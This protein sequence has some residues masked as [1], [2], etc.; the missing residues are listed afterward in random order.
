MSQRIP[1]AQAATLSAADLQ[2]LG[3]DELQDLGQQLVEW[4]WQ[5]RQEQQLLFYEPVSAEARKIHL[6]T[7]P[8]VCITG[9]NRSSK[10][11]TQLVE[12]AIQLTGLIPH[13]LEADYPREKI[14]PPIRARVVCASLTSTLEPIIKPKLRWDQWNGRD[15]RGGPGGHWGWIPRDFLYNGR[16]DDSYSDKYRTL[17]LT[18]GSTVQFMSYDQ[19]VQDFQGASMHLVLHD[20]GPP[21]GIYRENYV[22]TLD[23][24]GRLMLAMTPP[25]D[26]SAAWDAAWVYDDLYNKGLP[27]PAKEPHIDSFTLFTEDNRILDRSTIVSIG[28]NL[29]A[30]QREVRFSGRL[31]HLSGRIYPTYSDRPQWWCFSCHDIVLI[32][33]ERCVTCEATDVVEFCHVVEPVE[34][35]RPW[36]V[37]MVLDPHPRKP[38]CLAW[39]AIDPS[40]DVWQVAELE[41]DGSPVEVKVAVDQLETRYGL[42]V[43]YRLID[44]NMAESPSH[45]GGRRGVTVRDEFDAVGLRCDLADDNRHTARYRVRELLQPDPRTRAPRFHVFSR[46]ARTNY[47][48]QRYVWDEWTR[49]SS[50]KRDPKPMPREKHDDFPALIQYLANASPTFYGLQR[51]GAVVRVRSSGS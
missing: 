36:P 12:L 31:L 43:C 8:Q 7:A 18:N 29:T 30:A 47:Q 39:F 48:M 17:T 4:H 11:D 44:P 20:E 26:E 19:D 21:Q 27:G 42:N 13:S 3:P 9:G 35:A 22:R 38:H 37:V 10:T 5:R 6:S 40:D 1:L 25:D 50:D 32:D 28:R 33:G 46:C 15:P 41:V 45:A 51:R 16:W 23:V 24:G 14:R 2:A 34:P 49:Y